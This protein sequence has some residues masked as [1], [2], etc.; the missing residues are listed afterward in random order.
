MTFGAKG[1]QPAT[2]A[3][4]RGDVEQGLRIFGRAVLGRE[5]FENL[6]EA[7]MQQVRDNYI[8]AELLGSGFPPIDVDRLRLIMCPTLLMQGQRSPVLFHCLIDRLQ[9]LLPRSRR[10]EIAGA[11]HIA[12]EDNPE[13]F[14]AAVLSFLADQ[15]G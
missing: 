6:S 2:A 13:D 7:R 1:I 8:R 3:F 12:H 9:E 15:A 10:V 5:A 4:R 11:S 14:D